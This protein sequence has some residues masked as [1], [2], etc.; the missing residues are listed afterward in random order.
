MK[1][2]YQDLAVTIYHGD[3]R[4]LLNLAAVDAVITDPP[5]GIDYNHSGSH[6]R[7]AA[8]LTKNASQRGN[9]PIHGDDAPFDPS[10]W[11]GFVDNVILWGADHF[12]KR[13]PDSGRFLAWDKLA[14]M[15]PWDSF[16][17]VELA[18]HSKEGAARIFSMLWKGLACDKQ[19]ENNGLRDHPTQKPERLMRWCI[20][21]AKLE[22]GSLI[23]DP[24]MGSGTT[25]RAAKDLGHRAV[26][27]EID[28]KYC[29][30]AARRMG[31]EVL[32]LPNPHL[33]CAG[34]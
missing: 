15:Q 19:G 29:E 20:E 10:M 32:N 5:Y 16:C 27:V 6:G 1:P 8:G 22:A 4:E 31:Q 33:S 12:Y 30:I 18:W 24:Y 9:Y 28:E 34:R 3:C 25:L 17:D 2:Y 23:L 13:L 11:T 7:F 26:G 14:G 21:Q